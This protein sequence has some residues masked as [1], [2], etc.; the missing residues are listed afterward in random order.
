[1]GSLFATGSPIVNDAIYVNVSK[2]NLGGALIHTTHGDNLATNEKDYDPVDRCDD[3]LLAIIPK[4]RQRMYQVRDILTRV[5]DKGSFFEIGSRWGDGAIC[6]LT[7]TNGY[8]VGIL[9]FLV[10]L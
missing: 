7:R 2:E 9:S 4:R 6:G 10:V 1:M 3:S 5:I 8:V